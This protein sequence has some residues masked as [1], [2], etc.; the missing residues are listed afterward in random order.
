MTFHEYYYSCYYV[1]LP[2]LSENRLK[3]LCTDTLCLL[4]SNTRL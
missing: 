2:K 3:A 1:D 4:Y